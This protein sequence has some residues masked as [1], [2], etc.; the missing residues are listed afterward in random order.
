[1][2]AKL[3]IPDIFEIRVFLNKVYDVIISVHKVINKIYLVT[4]IIL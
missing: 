2:S 4:Q 1:M 3:A